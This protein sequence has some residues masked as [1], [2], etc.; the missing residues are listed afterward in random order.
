MSRLRVVV[1]CCEGRFQRYLV[2]RA[3]EEF[4]LVGVVW[5]VADPVTRPLAMRLRPYANPL[6]LLRHVVARAALPWFERRAAP[7]IDELFGPDVSPPLPA[8]VPPLRTTNI[9]ADEVVTQIT[10]L[11]PDIVLV[12]GTQLLREP[13][14]ALLPTIRFGIVNL[15]TGLSPYSR[16]GN[17]NLFML[18]EGH[19]QW[20]GVTVHHIDRGIDSGD[21][22]RTAQL[23]LR[24]EDSYEVLDARSFH[25]GIEL[26]LRAAQ[27]LNA[28]RASRVAQ[29]TEGKLFLRRT[30]Y[31][32]EPWQRLRANLCVASGA[33]RRYLRAGGHTR[34][35][36][37]TVS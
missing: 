14:L 9:N 7:V 10:E 33:V 20:L 6:R 26:L 16:G 34:H 23:D 15:H 36:V 2:R 11:R 28:G 24:P 13:I 25:Q 21:I 37:R 5:Q 35:P 22:I 30:G 18:L 17:C 27:D 8:G 3:A 29:W 31:V 32:Y 4:E 19:L 1:L 12:N